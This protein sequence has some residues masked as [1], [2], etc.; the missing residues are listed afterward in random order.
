MRSTVRKGFTLIELLIVV[1]IIGIL[2][3]IAVPRFSAAKERAYVRAMRSDLRNLVTSQENFFA[4]AGSYTTAVA[5]TGATAS[6]NVTLTISGVGTNP[7]TW[8]ASAAHTQTSR[9]C[10]LAVGGTSNGVIVCN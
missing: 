2:A 3:A 8:A 9:T 6:Q 7:S 4:D 5:A 10:G 1:V